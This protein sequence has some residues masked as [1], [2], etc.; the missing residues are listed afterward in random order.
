MNQKKGNKT[1]T[2]ARQQ[3]RLRETAARYASIASEMKRLEAEAAPLKD[4]LM[5]Y[6][7]SVGV[8]AMDLGSLMIERRTRVTA[9]IDEKRVTPD[10][11][12]RMQRDGYAH[13]LSI[14]VDAKDLDPGDARAESY[15]KEVGYEER[16][17]DTYALRL[18]TAWKPEGGER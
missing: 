16:T 9:R 7:R 2:A 5:Q 4:Q 1:T 13:A 11:L 18:N 10:W 17:A 6:A 3:E 14:K 8:M 12:Y 15:L